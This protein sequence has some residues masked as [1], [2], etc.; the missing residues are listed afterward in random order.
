M[1]K[2]ARLLADPLPGG[3]HTFA[4]RARDA[5]GN[6]GPAATARFSVDDQP[7]RSAALASV[8]AGYWR[9]GETEWGRPAR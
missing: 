9:L 3:E 4:V 2:P 8:A 1:R 7:Y 6:V 5:A